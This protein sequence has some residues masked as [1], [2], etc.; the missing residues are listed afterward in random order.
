MGGLQI[1][2]MPKKGLRK[3]VV[4]GKTYNYIIKKLLYGGHNNSRLTI[5]STNGNKYYSRSIIGEITPA[6]V[7][8]LIKENF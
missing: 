6:M 3:I 4:D 7:E 1:M 2:T 5:E 8:E